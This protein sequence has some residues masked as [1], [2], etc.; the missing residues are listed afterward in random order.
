LNFS[1]RIFLF[2][3]CPA[4]VAACLLLSLRFPQAAEADQKEWEAFISQCNTGFPCK[5][6]G[7][8]GSPHAR[9]VL[10]DLKTQ[11]ITW[12]GS[13]TVALGSVTEVLAGKQTKVCGVSV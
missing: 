1:K 3:L 6:H 11:L 13:E 10:L 8:W 12:G 5:K 7:R 9:V 4:R 2:L